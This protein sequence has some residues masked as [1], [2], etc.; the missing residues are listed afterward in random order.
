LSMGNGFILLPVL[1]VQLLIDTHE[2]LAYNETYRFGFL[3]SSGEQLGT[4]EKSSCVGIWL[5]C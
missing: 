2:A 1:S 4:D 3:C 5:I